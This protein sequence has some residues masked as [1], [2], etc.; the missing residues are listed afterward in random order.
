MKVLQIL[1]E[2]NS[3]GV[4]RGTLEI[5]AHLVRR[6][7]SALVISNGG[8][9]VGKLEESGAIHHTMPVHRKSLATLGQ[10][11]KMRA[12]LKEM[13]PDI[14]HVRS[15]VPAWVAWLAWR[16]MDPLTR[17]RLVSTVHGF[18]SVNAYSA[19][20]T[21]GE[22]VIAV[23][24]SIRDY[25]LASYP[26]IDEDRIH[27]IH[28]GVSPAEFP[29]GYRPDEAW[30]SDW[31]MNQPQL[32]GKKILL[33]PGRI[34]RWKGHENFLELLAA[35]KAGGHAVHGLV[36][37]D[38]HP[39]KQA[40]ATELTTRAAQLG[41]AEDLTF[42][43]HRSDVRDVMAVSDVVFSLSLDPEAFGRVSLEA[44]ALGRPV[45]GYDHGGVAEQLRVLYPQGLVPVGDVA[46]LAETTARILASPGEPAAVAAPFTL[47]SMCRATESVYQELLGS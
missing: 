15:R 41:V 19:I 34:T 40:Y 33:L 6:G 8:R 37:G 9:L 18:Y 5:A 4:E 27:V 11:R 29:R 36:L 13:R 38:T 26:K 12:V 17:P 1:P 10:V 35:L 7:H 39:R 31:R 25:L 24:N 2:L 32:V 21:R 3:G 45:I 20:M 14:L 22:R 28:R 46:T 44:A 30:M 42:L 47:E 23:S 16:G 43:G